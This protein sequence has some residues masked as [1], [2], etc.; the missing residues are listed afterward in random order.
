MNHFAH[1]VLAQPTLHS[2]VGNLLGDFM[3][4]VAA[5]ALEPAVRRGLDNHRA[6][7]RFTDQDAGIRALKVL[8]SPPRRRFAGVAL[9]IY[10]DHL[11][12][13][14]WEQLEDGT[15]EQQ[16]GLSY[17]RLRLG[18]AMMPSEKMRR[19]S[20][21]MVDEDWFGRYGDLENVGKAMD[22][23][24]SRIR[25]EHRFDNALE[26]ILQHRET[27]R[28]AFLNFYPRLKTHIGALDLE[29]P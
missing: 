21:R 2:T 17:R 25:F 28:D 16:I 20:T 12:I 7:D 5:D 15:A 18:R 26:E 19:V 29:R 24:A 4:G 9:D 10:F 11:L 6:V 23:V 3:R 22:R 13:R 8:F 27:I 1:L 14:H